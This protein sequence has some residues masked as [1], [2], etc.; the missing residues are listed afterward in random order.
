[1]DDAGEPRP[2]VA[3]QPLFRSQVLGEQQTQWL[4][5]I[6][7]RPRAAHR[8]FAACAALVTILIA[9]TLCTASYTRKARV[10]GWLVP[11]EGMVR[12]FSPRA[13]VATRL[14]VREGDQV[15]MGQVL[16]ALSTEEKSA[17]LGDTQARAIRELE[18]QRDSL[19]AEQERAAQRFRQQRATLAERLAATQA[20]QQQMEQE[21][22]AQKSRVSLARQAELHLRELKSRG[23]ISEQQTLTAADARLDR[24]GKLRAL[25]RGLTSLGR[26]GAALNGELQ[27][28]PLKLAAQN[29]LTARALAAISRELGE[30][31]ARRELLISA[32]SAGTVTAIHAGVG[33]AVH[34]GTPLLSIVPRGAT[35]EAHLYASSRS[36]GFVRPGQPVLLRYQ[37]YPYQK[38]GHYRGT[39]KSI[40]RT[41][42]EPAEL[43]PQFAAAGSAGEALYRITV[44][45]GRQDVTA[46]GAPV[47]LQ[48]GMQLEADIALERRRLVE[49]VLEP[50]F[51]LTG[52]WER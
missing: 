5:P 50:L 13:A 37:A 4:G 10:S 9:A 32:P 43:P 26:D 33:A 45:L 22:A 14:L 12:V 21:I 3:N 47:P 17:A 24:V 27:D 35:L 36:I 52:K 49:W 1:M 31:E 18:A 39:I 25:Q 28:L 23:F 2:P 42:I 44:A 7:L 41:G 6:L 16:L 8:W 15:G 48:P 38:F 34:P 30:V 20:E 46:Y 51:T 29:A 11:S 19:R 40:S